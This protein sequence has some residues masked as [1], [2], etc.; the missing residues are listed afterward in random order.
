METETNLATGRQLMVPAGSWVVNKSGLVPRW[1]DSSTAESAVRNRT[2]TFILSDQNTAR[3]FE[4]HN[5]E[6]SDNKS[7]QESWSKCIS[8][9][10]KRELV[11]LIS[12]LRRDRL[13]HLRQ[14][15]ADYFFSHVG[16]N[17]RNKKSHSCIKRYD[18]HGKKC[19]L[20][21]KWD[22]FRRFRNA[23]QLGHA[24]IANECNLVLWLPFI[25]S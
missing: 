9:S 13:S 15:C 23:D 16:K 18:A 5:D 25:T 22:R 11:M 3:Y 8:G 4:Q 20:A 24:P 17:R 1:S 6:S 14:I 2:G 21:V 12:S 7:L 19:T 10:S